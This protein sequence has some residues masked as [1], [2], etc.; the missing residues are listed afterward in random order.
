MERVIAYVDGFNLYF[1]LKEQ[2]WKRFY[3][4]NIQRLAQRL[5]KPHQRLV[6]TKYFTSR[7][8]STPDDPQK[9]KRQG[10]YLEALQT[11]PDLEIYY[12][13]YLKKFVRCRGCGRSWPVYDEK[14]TDVNIAVQLL[15]DAYQHRLDTALIMSGD[16][17]LAGCIQQV[18]RLF[19]TKVIAAFPPERASQALRRAATVWLPIDRQGL[20]YS[21]FPDEVTK[22]DGY[23]LRRPEGWRSR[24]GGEHK[25]KAKRKGKRGSERSS[26]KR[27]RDQ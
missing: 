20:L 7:V 19:D 22:P 26:K 1:G 12:G 5:L 8:S 3:W 17:D 27:G 2:G 16:S 18:R 13:N 4:L 24:Q 9:H 11:L 10:I 6:Q 23:I 21:Q 15:S 25:G 14:M